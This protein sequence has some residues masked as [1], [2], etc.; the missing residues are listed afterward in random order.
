MIFFR[1]VSTNTKTILNEYNSSGFNKALN[2]D[3]KNIFGEIKFELFRDFL[4]GAKVFE[5]RRK[6]SQI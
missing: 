1:F 2:L 4:F 3:W 5:W 6:K